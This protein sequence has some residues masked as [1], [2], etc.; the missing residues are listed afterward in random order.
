[1]ISLWSKITR[2]NEPSDEAIFHDCGKLH[3]HNGRIWAYEEPRGVSE[4]ERDTPE[5]TVWLG[6]RYSI[7]YGPFFIA[8]KS[9]TGKIY[10]NMLELFLEPPLQGDGILDTFV[11]QQDGAPPQS[12]HIVR[13]Y[14]T[15][16]WRWIGRE[17]PRLWAS[18]SPDLNPNFF[19]WG[20]NNSKVYTS[21]FN[22]LPDL[23]NCIREAAGLIT[24]QMLRSTFRS[25]NERWS[26][27]FYLD[28]GHV[29]RQ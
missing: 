1:M 4:W 28:G 9:I 21:K 7:L 25:T 18:S 8:E 16:P 14:K 6:M 17:S 2:F 19:A 22:A 12:A 24:V 11:F 29:E 10:L 23:H 26:M 13:D 27:C 15:F 3:R 20:Y 5:V